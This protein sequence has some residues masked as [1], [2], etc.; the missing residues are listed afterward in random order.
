MRYFL[1][2]SCSRQWRFPVKRGSA[3]DEGGVA[4]TDNGE[5]G[6]TEGGNTEGGDGDEGGTST[7]GNNSGGGNNSSGG[8]NNSSGGGTLPTAT[9]IKSTYPMM[10]KLIMTVIPRIR[11]ET[12]P[13]PRPM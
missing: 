4:D 6:S 5:G 9:V 3:D 2:F 1:L 13:I 11:T 7:D 10:R 12:L 8:G